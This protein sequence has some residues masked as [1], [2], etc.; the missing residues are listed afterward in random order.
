[1]QQANDDDEFHAWIWILKNLGCYTVD[2]SLSGSATVSD[3]FDDASIVLD[4]SGSL[5]PFLDALVAK[6]NEITIPD[7]SLTAPASSPELYNYESRYPND[8]YIDVNDE[9]IRQY[10][11]CEASKD[12]DALR[13]LLEKHAVKNHFTPDPEFATSPIC[14]KD[15]YNTNLI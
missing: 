15:D 5:G 8:S 3:E 12:P 4:D 11:D 9:F 13:K 14:I 1:M 6:S 7:K 10:M 2:A